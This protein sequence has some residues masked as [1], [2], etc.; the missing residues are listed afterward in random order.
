MNGIEWVAADAI[1]LAT[2]VGVAL[3]AL[4]ALM[5][6]VVWMFRGGEAWLIYLLS[7]AL[8]VTGGVAFVTGLENDPIALNARS[9][10]SGYGLE[11]EDALALARTGTDKGAVVVLDGEK[12]HASIRLSSDGGQAFLI[13]DGKRA[14]LAR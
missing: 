13:A 2:T 11:V 7:A 10:Q 8:V 4:G 12:V 1:P 14:A 3:G 9:L 5:S 6:F